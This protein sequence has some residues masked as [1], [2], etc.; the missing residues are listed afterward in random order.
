M[1]YIGRIVQYNT[2]KINK[3]GFTDNPNNNVSFSVNK[4]VQLAI[5]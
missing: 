3:K 4:I 1:D 5:I 2:A